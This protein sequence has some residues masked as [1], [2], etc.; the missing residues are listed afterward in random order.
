[1][2]APSQLAKKPH[3]KP[4]GEQDC[5]TA[6]LQDC[7]TILCDLLMADQADFWS[8]AFLVFKIAV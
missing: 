7:R 2:V 8:A 1:M 6:G 3:C 5:R 4:L